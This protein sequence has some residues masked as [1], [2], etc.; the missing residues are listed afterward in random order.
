MNRT[1]ICIDLKS[2]YA[3]VECV[4][5]N[6]DPLTTNLVVADKERTEKT[7]CLAV[8]PAL[9]SFGLPGRA[10][11]FEV[12]QKVKEI[13]YERKRKAKVNK[14]SNKSSNINELN[15]HLDY[16]LDFLIAPPQMALY[17]EVSTKIYNIYLRFVSSED[18]H[19]Y[20]IDE[21]FMD[22]TK[23]LK[24]SKM[25]AK[26]FANKIIKTVLKETGI[27]ATAGIG[28]NMYLAKV[29]MDI[30][31]KHIPA[32]ENSVRVAELDEMEYRKKL[33]SHRPLK[34]FWRVGS[35]Y[36]RRLEN[37]G[38]YTMGDIARCSLGSNNQYYNEDLLYKEFGVNAELLID[39]A[40][41]YEPTTIEDIKAY[42]PKS[43]SLSS[44]QVLS[45]GY[46]YDKARLIVKEMTDLLALDLVDK[47]LVTKHLTL[48]I[49]YDIDNLKSNDYDG[50]TTTDYMGRVIPKG[51]HG[52][53][54]L[55]DFTSS[56]KEMI[57]AI[58]KLYDRITNK[59]LLVR[60][61]NIGVIIYDEKILE[62]RTVY[63]Q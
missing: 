50:E 18:I 30:V 46:T 7:I 35:G 6:L 29:A 25:N 54:N 38:L 5:R 34:D 19:V 2:F 28:T 40:W 44:G 3:S 49:G 8:S 53:I 1:Y 57:Y 17:I 26:E 51:S 32:D 62:N 39:H 36:V 31:A 11:L 42:K 22:V 12:N 63:A 52:S 13:N 10:R 55:D 20:S 61:I 27:T 47:G 16:E 58:T 37:L 33:W 43:N 4:I 45:E 56:S 60:R 15:E 24:Q 14:F 59:N 23:Y 48:S 9:K 41:G 21:V